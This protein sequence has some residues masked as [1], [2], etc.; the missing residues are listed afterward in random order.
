MPAPTPP[1]RRLLGP[2]SLN[3]TDIPVNSQASHQLQL[4]MHHVNTRGTGRRGQQAARRPPSRRGGA[5][6]RVGPW[7]RDRLAAPRS[8]TAGWGGG[9][10]L[11]NAAG[12]PLIPAPPTAGGGRGRIRRSLGVGSLGAALGPAVPRLR[13]PGST[14]AA[15]TGGRRGRAGGDARTRSPGA[16][17]RP[18]G[19]GG[20]GRKCYRPVPEQ[21]RGA[22]GSQGPAGARDPRGVGVSGPP[23]P[24]GSR[25]PAP[26]PR[27]RPGTYGR[28]AGSVGPRSPA[29]H[30][31]ALEAACGRAAP[32][33][34]RP[35]RA[36]RAA[37]PHG[38][39]SAAASPPLGRSPAAPRRSRSPNPRPPQAPPPRP[40][41][42]VASRR[43]ASR[44]GRPRPASR[45]APPPPRP[46]PGLVPR[47]R[48]RPAPQAGPRP[49]PKP[50]RERV[51]GKEFGDR[52]GAQRRPAEP[53][54]GLCPPNREAA[55]ASPV[56][57]AGGAG[58]AT[59]DAACGAAR[60]PTRRAQAQAA[61]RCPPPPGRHLAARRPEGSDCWEPTWRP[62]GRGRAGPWPRARDASNRG[63]D[64]LRQTGRNRGHLR[65]P[66]R[67][68]PSARLEDIT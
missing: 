26:P 20:R 64:L 65:A 31:A 46:F 33:L 35:P 4:I 27:G 43:V 52:G 41:P 62:R 22:A 56:T 51:A 60:P 36:G 59:R 5:R 67:A 48:P 10:P 24:R 18:P 49:H 17:P 42:R 28:R 40:R 21:P 50:P 8:P 38:V 39:T 34:Q 3:L 66:G 2:E 9:A 16:A 47:H 11:P 44:H 54:P 14:P 68:V 53:R 37:R 63:R 19:G 23:H 13:A 45:Q 32:D 6:T 61:S 58:A 57:H 29:L 30:P 1:Q 25:V 15:G 12:G 55:C 7:A